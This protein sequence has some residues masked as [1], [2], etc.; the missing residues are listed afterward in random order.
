MKIV[1]R[2]EL[3]AVLLLMI[4][5]AGCFTSNNMFSNKGDVL[6]I[7]AST[8]EEVEKVL[9]YDDSGDVYEVTPSNSGNVLALV[10]ARII[11]QKSTQISLFVD[12]SAAN[13]SIIE[14][15]KA[16]PIYYLERGVKSSEVIPSEYKYGP[17]IWGQVDIPLGYE[18]NGWMMFEVTK[19]SE[20]HS[21]IWEDEDFVRIMYP[22]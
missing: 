18:I 7:V 20:Y 16:D 10:Q 5:V 17:F 6:Q 1:L 4:L 14:S 9:Y 15:P 2:Y 13:L 22:R 11:N 21:F 12:E 19:G 3:S 8:V